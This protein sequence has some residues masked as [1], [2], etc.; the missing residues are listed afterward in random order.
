MATIDSSSISFS[1]LQD[2]WSNASPNFAGG[3]DPGTSNISI[4]EFHGATFTSGSAIEAEAGDSVSIDTHFKGR[5]FGSGTVALTSVSIT[6]DT[7]PFT[8]MGNPYTY[9]AVPNSGATGVTYTWEWDD[10][11]EQQGIP[12]SSTGGIV[13]GDTITP[14]ITFTVGLGTTSVLK[15][16][17]SQSGA[18]D[19]T[20]TLSLFVF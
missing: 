5:T 1:H 2:A 13:D 3:S 15:V 12:A 8:T 6:G 4:S 17:A 9:T 18:S 11:G 10:S 19:V 20:G 14:D 7:N 16:T